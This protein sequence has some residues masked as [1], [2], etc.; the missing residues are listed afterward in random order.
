MIKHNDFW[1]RLVL[2][3]KI[4]IDTLLELMKAYNVNLNSLQKELPSINKASE[5]RFR[6]ANWESIQE[7]TAPLVSKH[8]FSIEQYQSGTTEQPYMTT[9]IKHN[10][11]YFEEHQC[12]MMNMDKYES[13]QEN[14]AAITYYK[15]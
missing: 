11:G 4:T 3:D 13:P 5:G 12:P 15:R 9:I 2:N 10:C 1:L 7:Q 6:Y 14:G 8:G